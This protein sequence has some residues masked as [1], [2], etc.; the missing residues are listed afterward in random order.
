[1]KA[2]VFKVR[3]KE[4]VKEIRK[5]HFPRIRYVIIIHQRKQDFYMSMLSLPFGGCLLRVDKLCRKM[6]PNAL[7]ATVVHELAHKTIDDER[8]CDMEVIRIGYGN[9]LLAFHDWHNKRYKSYKKHEG[10]TRREVSKAIKK[11]LVA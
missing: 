5:K 9:E 11:S 7:K 3:I 6:P 10:L 8:M 4:M 1:M 2:E